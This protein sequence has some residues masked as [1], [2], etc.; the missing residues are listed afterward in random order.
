MMALDL[1]RLFTAINVTK[2]AP[3]ISTI[4]SALIEVAS[5]INA[6]ESDKVE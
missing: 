2:P 3:E 4:K 1:L 6:L 5:P